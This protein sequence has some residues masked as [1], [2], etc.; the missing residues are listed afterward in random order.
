MLAWFGQRMTAG[1]QQEEGGTA[2]SGS[3]PSALTDAEAATEAFPMLPSWAPEVVQNFWRMLESHPTLVF[4]LIVAL[5][6]IAAN[7][8]STLIRRGLARLTAKTETELDDRLV[9]LLHRPVFQ[10]VFLCGLAL[11]TRTLGLPVGF[12]NN[13]VNILQSIVVLAWL[14][15][16]F[17]ICRLALDFLG[18]LQNRFELVEERTIPLFEITM[19]LIIFGGATYVFLQIWSIDA[20]AWLASA[21]VVGIAVGFAAKDTLANLF[22]GFFIVADA[23]YKLGD[24]VVL[25]S[26]ERGM[27]TNVGIRSTRLLTR[28]DIEITVPNALIANGKIINESGGPSEAERIRI[29]VGVAY[30][31]DV[32]Q[33]CAVL[34]KLAVEHDH[35][36]A[37]PTPRVRLRG[38]GASSLDFELL[39]WIDNP[40]LRGKLSHELYMEVYKTFGDLGIEI[41][42]TQAD[43]HI[44][45]IP[46][47]WMSG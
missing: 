30:G 34:N 27:I 44:K 33:V 24:F 35:I 5:G 46:A 13:V 1:S 25:T 19:K 43:L 45:E 41:P 36:R 6:F 20:T 47:A 9:E 28:D 7:L 14:F 17:P 37:A 21:G 31:S 16:G 38:F 10:T 18:A 4:V 12:T 26:G 11:A 22:S 39:C 40:V 32:D 3:T 42:F 8:A 2:T 29:K 15:A 23:P